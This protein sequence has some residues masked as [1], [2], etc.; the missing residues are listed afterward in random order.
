MNRF[1]Q[2][3]TFNLNNQNMF[4]SVRYL[5]LPRIGGRW[6]DVGQRNCFLK[7]V[8]SETVRVVHNYRQMTDSSDYNPTLAVTTKQVEYVV[9]VFD[10]AI[11]TKTVS[12]L[13]KI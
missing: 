5:I 10:V 12:K 2:I 9:V 7:Q 4:L 8:K 3:N 13:K 1:K 6:P 11:I